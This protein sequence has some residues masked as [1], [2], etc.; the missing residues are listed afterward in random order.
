LKPTKGG[1]KQR[2][3]GGEKA[4]KRPFV[5]GEPRRRG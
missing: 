5:A 3:Y 2:L 1:A 4:E